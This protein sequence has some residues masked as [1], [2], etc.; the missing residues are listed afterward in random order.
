LTAARGNRTHAAILL[1]VQRTYLLR[2][3]RDLGITAPPLERRPRRGDG[4]PPGPIDPADVRIVI[5]GS[6]LRPPPACD[7]ND[8]PGRGLRAPEPC[9]VA[10]TG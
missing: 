8:P 9:E 2:L 1:G 6:A 4:P 10:A 3:M 7:S 5:T